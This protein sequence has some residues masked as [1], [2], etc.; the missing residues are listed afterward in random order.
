MFNQFSNKYD[1]LYNSTLINNNTVTGS[2][3]LNNY[4]NAGSLTVILIVGGIDTTMTTIRL[5]QSTDNSTW[6]DITGA[7][8]NSAAY[9]A[10]DDNKIC[11]QP[12]SL[13]GKQRYIQF[14]GLVGNGSTGATVTV[15]GIVGDNMQ[16]PIKNNATSYSPSSNDV[17]F[18]GSIV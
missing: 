13:A 15:I 14:S 10:T 12:I 1:I 9:T 6:A 4:P 11:I 18:A 3:D 7:N 2:I 16:S 17:L 5:R 8:F